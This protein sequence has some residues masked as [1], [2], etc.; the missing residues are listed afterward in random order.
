MSLKQKSIF[1]CFILS[2]FS[3]WIYIA[4]HYIEWLTTLYMHSTPEPK[5]ATGCHYLDDLD[6]EGVI[7]WVA[8]L[9]KGETKCLVPVNGDL[10]EVLV[11]Q[12]QPNLQRETRVSPEW[13][14]QLLPALTHPCYMFCNVRRKIFLFTFSDKMK[15]I[16]SISPPSPLRRGRYGVK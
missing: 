2:V 16:T 7:V 13:H 1:Y 11:S 8:A 12:C 10:V 6:T 14:Q 15:V 5:L 9:I 3:K 4:L